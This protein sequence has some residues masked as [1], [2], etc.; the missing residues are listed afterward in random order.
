MERRNVQPQCHHCPSRSMQRSIQRPEHQ[1]RVWENLQRPLAIG[2]AYD[3]WQVRL[4]RSFVAELKVHV[5]VPS[6]VLVTIADV[7][8]YVAGLERVAVAAQFDRSFLEMP[9]QCEQLEAIDL[10]T[11]DDRV[12]VIAFSAVVSLKEDRSIEERVHRG[13]DWPSDVDPDVNVARP[14]EQRAG[15]HPLAFLVV[16]PD[17]ER[18]RQRAHR[19]ESAREV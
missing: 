6:A 17:P 11:R 12:P 2:L 13:A 9:E 18:A 7:A 19:I 10:V 1:P 8:Q 5:R 15:I 16:L 3:T 4:R 14:A